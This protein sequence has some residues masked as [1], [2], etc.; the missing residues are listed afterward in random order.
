M[1][2]GRV[3]NRIL[4]KYKKAWEKRDPQLATELFTPD[5]T[6]REDPFD[7]RPMRGIREIRDYW[8]KVPKF[9]RNIRFSHG[10]VFRVGRSRVWGTEWSASYTKVQTGE[11]IRLRGVLFCELASRRVRRFWEYWHASGGKPSFR[12]GNS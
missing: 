1:R 10:P 7:K 6:Y 5:A 12:A 9:Q 2:N 3:F 11:R 8:T 4:S